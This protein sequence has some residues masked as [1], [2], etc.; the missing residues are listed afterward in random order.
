MKKSL[1][2]KLMTA[3]IA[4]TVS[5]VMCFPLSASAYEGTYVNSYS[6]Y[7]TTKSGYSAHGLLV[8][9]TKEVEAK[10]VIYNGAPDLCRVT[11]WAN[12]QN[13]SGVY[14][15]V[16]MGYDQGHGSAYFD[17]VKPNNPMKGAYCYHSAGSASVAAKVGTY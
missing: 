9:Y 11:V 12:M 4:T 14:S 3:I 2:K 10:T 1:L 8:L 17:T 7:F 5:V 16:Y 6:Q 15:R 13:S